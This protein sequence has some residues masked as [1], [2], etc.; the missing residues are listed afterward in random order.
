MKYNHSRRKFI[1]G[2]GLTAGASV[3]GTSWTM[4]EPPRGNRAGLAQRSLKRVLSFTKKYST[5]SCLCGL[6][7]ATQATGGRIKSSVNMLV[8]VSDTDRLI[9]ALQ[10][11]KG[12]PFRKVY[13]AGNVMSF[14]YSSR[15]YVIENLDPSTYAARVAQVQSFG[16][17]SEEKD[18]AYAHDYVTFELSSQKVTDPYKAIHGKKIELKKVTGKN[19]PLDFTDVIN[20]MLGCA[21]LHIEPSSVTASEWATILANTNPSD[22]E[23]IVNTLLMRLHEISTTLKQESVVDLILSPLVS[24]SSHSVLGARGQKIVSCFKQIRARS[25][26]STHPSIV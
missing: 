24:G 22:P 3:A 1:R 4:A 2:L 18:A 25:T 8:S 23:G 16:V 12:L 15:D 19:V 21:T 6:S 11:E 7:A 17:R 20:G 5:E 13:T 9:E 14:Q 26:R 10:Q